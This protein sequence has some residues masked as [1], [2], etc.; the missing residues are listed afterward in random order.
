VRN[1]AANYAYVGVM[2]LVTLFVVPGYV[3]LLGPAQWGN[4]AL[5]ITLQGLL[6]SMDMALGP[7]MLRDVARAA[8][9][10]RARH[11]YERFLRWYAMPAL[12]VFG[13]GQF[14]VSAYAHYRIEQSSALS[15]DLILAIRLALLQFAFQFSNNAAIGYWSGREQQGRANRRLAAFALAKHATALASLLLWQATVLAY[16]LPFVLISALE[17]LWNALS[18]RND[19]ADAPH[20]S[21]AP[22][23][24]AAYRDVLGYAGAALLA[25]ASTQIDRAYLSVALPTAQYGI[26]VLVSSLMLSMLSLQMPIQRAFL[27]RLATSAAPR[28][29]ARQMRR[30]LFVL[31]VVPALLMAAFPEFILRCWL[32]DPVI[33]AQGAAT[34]R[35]LLLAVALM[36]LAGPT[37][38]LLLH[39]HRNATMTRLNIVLLCTQFAILLLVAPRWGMLA[40]AVAWAASAAIQLGFAIY[41][42]RVGHSND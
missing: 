8:A 35:L 36:A 23:E 12:F 3:R 28:A 29:V 9:Q 42:H 11:A 26:Y 37:S 15:P 25:V 20:E 7:L 17:F 14:V 31:L 33:A 41:W 10:G 30:L 21:T 22:I 6:F 4:V 16:M 13:L 1:I 5:C 27:P 18:T 34:F 24:P 2:A 32:H 19:V 38:L 40:G 39:Y